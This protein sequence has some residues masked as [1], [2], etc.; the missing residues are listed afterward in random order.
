LLLLSAHHYSPVSL[1]STTRSL[2]N[3]SI[4]P[5]AWKKAYD[6]AV[7]SLFMPSV[8]VKS[9]I[10]KQLSILRNPFTMTIAGASA[11]IFFGSMLIA[12]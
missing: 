3:V 1:F 9:R 2:S 10:S 4:L 7:G 8:L 11:A 12:P 5:A 6:T